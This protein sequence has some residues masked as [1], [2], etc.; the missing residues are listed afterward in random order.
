MKTI[1]K[2]MVLLLAGA[3]FVAC[4][5]D[6]SFDEN[7][8]KEAAEAQKEAEVAKLY[9]TYESDFVKTFGSIAPGHDWGFGR[10][11]GISTRGEA[12]VSTSECWD[13]PSNFLNPSESKEGKYANEIKKQSNKDKISDDLN[14]NFNNYLLQHVEKPNK[15]KKKFGQ[16]W[17]WSS[18]ERAWIEVTHF[19]EGQ[20][21][22]PKFSVGGLNKALKG[23]TL[24][25][26]MGGEA[27]NNEN[28]NLDPANGKLFRFGSPNNWHYDYKFFTYNGETFLCLKYNDNW[29]FIKIAAVQITN[30]IAA[31]GRIFCE[32][33]GSNDFDFNDVV[34]DAV[35]KKSTKKIEITVLAHGGILPIYIDGTKVSLD[36]MSN[37]GLKTVGVQTF[38]IDPVDGDFKYPNV[39][40]IPVEVRPGGDANSYVLG[41]NTGKSPQ[42]ICTFRGTPWPDEYVSIL[43][44]YPDFQGWVNTTQPNEWEHYVVKRLVD[45]NKDNNAEDYIEPVEDDE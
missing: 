12:V 11:T 22:N 6:V 10:T 44:A 7:A 21:N 2:G 16:L 40:S 14:I 32:D 20:N 1:I 28:N 18:E 24:M 3:S 37:T 38:E 42:K 34:F 8:Q 35:F 23:T 9:A 17:A 45:K 41:A 4:S 36:Q 5:K 15:D 29:W 30:D 31:E 26:G 39:V 27:Y 13:I 43:R 19:A 33:M 25:K